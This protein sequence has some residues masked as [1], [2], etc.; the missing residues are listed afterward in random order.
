MK[1]IHLIKYDNVHII[2]VICITIYAPPISL[3]ATTYFTDEIL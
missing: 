1:I 3:Q 2:I